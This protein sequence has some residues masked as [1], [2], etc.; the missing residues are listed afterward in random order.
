[1]GEIWCLLDSRGMG[2]IE[3]H[4]AELAAGL[5]AAGRE[6]RVVFLADHGP[7]PLHQRLDGAGVAWEVLPGGFG[8]L[9]ARLKSGRPAILHTHGYKA[10]LL[11]RIAAHMA[12]VPTVASYHAGEKPPGMLAWYDRLDRWTSC[13][14]GR[15][16]VSR[17]ILARLPWGGTLVPNF[18]ALPEQPEGGA[19]DSVGF[20]GRM[21]H[22]KGPDVFAALAAAVPELR[23][24]A[25]G[26]GPMLAALRAA[27][28]RVAFRGARAGMAGAW[29]E[30]GLL[31]VTSRAEG[32]P[33]AVLEAMANGV[34]VAAFAVG[35]LPEV[36]ADGENGFLAP[37]GDVAALAAALRRWRLADRTAMSAAARATVAARFG[38][39]AG[40]AAILAVYA[41]R[42]RAPAKS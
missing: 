27:G 20:V 23:F 8:A 6:V 35:A 39:A 12:G 7:H 16:A 34:P 42:S 24:I 22:E 15:I 21:S 18:V 33:L 40:V 26:D 32:L 25:F 41:A 37:P 31:A 1:M 19:S 10:N 2:G 13:L 9:L 11:G 3:S 38:R 17:P 30:I 14:G 4:V 5:L 28:G 36:I 29:G